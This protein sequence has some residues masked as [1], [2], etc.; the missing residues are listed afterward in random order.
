MRRRMRRRRGVRWVALCLLV[1]HLPCS[2]SGNIDG[3]NI[4]TGSYHPVSI[5]ISSRSGG[6]GSAAT[7]TALGPPL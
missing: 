1:Y 7:T 2:S 5:L 6:S 4:A 3:N